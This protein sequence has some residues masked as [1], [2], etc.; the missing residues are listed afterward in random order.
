MCFELSPGNSITKKRSHMKLSRTANNKP[1]IKMTKKEWQDIGCQ[2]GWIKE[3]K[4]KKDTNPR[5]KK[6]PQDGRG[7]GKGMSGGLRGG[8]M[9]KDCPTKEGPG[10]GK[11]KGQGKGKNR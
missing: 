5:G 6:R 8:K 2:N 1:I 11:G 7:K 9:D 3:A 10:Y 4:K